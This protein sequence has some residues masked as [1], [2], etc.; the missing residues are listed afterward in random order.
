[1]KAKS[2]VLVGVLPVALALA[3]CDQVKKLVGGT[4]KG[5]V[6]ATVNGEEITT[7]ELNRELGGFVSKDPAV[8]KAA[9]Q[10]ALQQ[11]IMRDLLTQKAKA[12]KL[13]KSPDYTLQVRRGEETLLAQLYQRKLAAAVATPTR[14]DAASFVASHPTMFAQHRILIVNQVAA[15]PGGKIKPDQ[16][17]AL[18]T[19]EEVKALFDAQGV[20]YRENVTTVDTLNTDPRMIEQIDKLPPGEVFI[21][22][23][24][25][26]LTF[27]RL[28]QAKALPIRGDVAENYA[29]GV[30]RNQKA[31]DLVRTKMIALRSGAEKSIVYNPA[32]KPAKPFT[33]PP[34]PGATSAPATTPAPAAAAPSADVKAPAAK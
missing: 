31:Q 27:N 4:P 6:V 34:A 23:Q 17:K 2:L 14:D 19:L 20:P 24:N 3:G 26:V 32:Y 8:M 7:M 22:P 33:P 10:Q 12:E 18:K 28:E 5:Q 9:Q 25:G 29:L 11:I 21:V 30:L 16:F 1:L 15:R 13:D